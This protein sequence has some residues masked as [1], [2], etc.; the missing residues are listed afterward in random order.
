MV[1]LIVRD[2]PGTILAGKYELLERAGS[3]GMAVVWR[4]RTLGASGF[5]RP[6]A[7]KRI[8]PHLATDPEFVAMFVEESRVV[9]ELQHPAVTQI[10]DFGVDDHGHHFLVMEWVEG[11]DLGELVEGWTLV[12]ETAPW[13]VV[14][15]IGCSV[16]EGLGAAHERT[17]PSGEPAPIFHRDVTPQNVRVSTSGEVKLTD[18]GIARAMDRSTMTRPDAIKGKVSYVAP[19]MLKGAAASATTD[20]FCTGIV[21]WEA[22]AQ[23]RLFEAPTD[24]QVMF[25]VHEAR[26][27]PLADVRAGLPPA[28]VS[29]VHRALSRDAADRFPTAREMG[30]ALATALREA[31]EPVDTGRIAEAVAKARR[32]RASAPGALH[33]KKPKTEVL[34]LDELEEIE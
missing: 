4:G 30:R 2:A 17:T 31:P 22:L 8:I 24:M 32:S 20:V 9:S 28:L 13:E 23:R 3:G 27:P 14:T 6:V 25:M 18:F 5:S 12:G 34:D 16:L 15:S 21:L 11:L 26:V 19:E 1:A 33:A 29:A 10:H 7:I